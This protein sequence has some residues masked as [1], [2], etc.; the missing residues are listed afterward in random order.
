MFQTK[1][2]EQIKTHFVLINLFFE[3]RACCEIM[4]KNSVELGRPQMKIRLKR[5][6][7]WIHKATNTYSGYVI[8]I[9]FPL[10]HWFYERTSVLSYAY[11]ACLV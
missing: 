5:I 9:T 4:W 3:S 1:F 10:Q 8:L 11:I 6:A 2:V 7:G